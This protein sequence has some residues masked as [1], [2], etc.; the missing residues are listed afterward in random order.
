LR[1]QITVI[2]LLLFLLK[3]TVHMNKLLRLFNKLHFK[4]YVSNLIHIKSLIEVSQFIFYTINKKTVF[5]NLFM[6]S[7]EYLTPFFFIAIFFNKRALTNIDFIFKNLVYSPKF[8]TNHTAKLKRLN[9]NTHLIYAQIIN[10]F[11]QL[12]NKHPHLNR[13][14]L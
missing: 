6:I 13:I 9:V 11:K 7:R 14:N 2:I 10:K 1:K 5:S 3:V 12:E 8:I 4:P